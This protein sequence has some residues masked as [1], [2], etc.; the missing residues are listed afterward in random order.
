MEL[1]VRIA[2]DGYIKTILK[3]TNPY[4][5]QVI[6]VSTKKKEVSIFK[7]SPR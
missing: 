3:I 4:Y 6:V 7:L 5:V 1:E 2:I